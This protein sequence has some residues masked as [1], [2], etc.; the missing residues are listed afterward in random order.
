MGFVTTVS[1]VLE[2]VENTIEVQFQRQISWISYIHEQF[3]DLLR[4]L[5][6]G[7]EGTNVLQEEIPVTI[8]DLL[9]NDTIV[10]QLFRP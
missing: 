8:K 7:D 9:T 2:Q 3:S 10:V 6:Q 1:W 5:K 4:M